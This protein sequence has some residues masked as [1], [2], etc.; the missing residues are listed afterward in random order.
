MK[1]FTQVPS[2]KRK[3]KVHKLTYTQKK[4]NGDITDEIRPFKAHI[5]PNQAMPNSIY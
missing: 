2:R 3:K 1:N 4:M 5:W